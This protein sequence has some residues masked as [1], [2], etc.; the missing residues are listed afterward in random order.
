MS[1]WATWRGWG[2][3]WT[4]VNVSQHTARVA[5]AAVVRPGLTGPQ[6]RE[7][8]RELLFKRETEHLC[9]RQRPGLTGPQPWYLRQVCRGR[10]QDSILKR[11]LRQT[12]LVHVDTVFKPVLS[13]VSPTW[14]YC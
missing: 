8:E 13:E 9:L 11:S 3:R 12:G 1:K 2:Q 5:G 6:E 7:R 14:V 4:L 10:G